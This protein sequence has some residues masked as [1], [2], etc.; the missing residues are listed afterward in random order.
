MTKRF[1]TGRFDSLD[2]APLTEVS[3]Q[4]SYAAAAYAWP[5]KQKNKK[6]VRALNMLYH[7][8][9]APKIITGILSPYSK[10]LKEP[11]DQ[12]LGSAEKLRQRP[13]KAILTFLSF[14]SA[15]RGQ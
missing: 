3:A 8:V 9:P 14:K 15:D 12:Y 2:N 13:T 1:L 6:K 7:S 10:Y 4:I 5:A 11:V